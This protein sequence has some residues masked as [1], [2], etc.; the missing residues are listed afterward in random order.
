[1]CYLE[2]LRKKL[3]LYLLVFLFVVVLDQLVKNLLLSRVG[4]NQGREFIPGII[5]FSVVQNTGGAFSIFSNCPVFFQIIGV[6][7]VIIF[8]Y[9]TFFPSDRFNEIIKLGCACI[10]GGTGGNLIDRFLRGGVV[11]YLDL[12]LFDFAVFNLADVFINIG[13]ILILIGWF[14]CRGKPVSLLKTDE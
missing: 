2:F 13:V 3:L 8:S 11:D 10:L 6:I 12:Q 7:N 9:L 1:M 4:L 14:L 5:Q